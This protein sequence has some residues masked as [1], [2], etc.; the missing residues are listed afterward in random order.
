MT[1]SETRLIGGR[2]RLGERLGTGAMGIVWSAY[3]ELLHRN[4]AVKEVQLP[5]GMPDDEADAVRERTLREARAVAALNQANVITVFDVAVTDGAPFVV[6]ELVTGR[7]LAGLLRASG[8]LDEQAA[9]LIAD[10][11][12]AALGAAHRTG[13]THRDVKPGNVLLGDGG[14]VRLTDFG[15]A[16]SVAESTMTHTGIILGSPAYIAP[17]IAEG[18]KAAP[19]ADLWSLGATLF[20]AVTGRPPYEPDG[21]IVATLHQVVDGEVPDPE[22]D[23][24]LGEVVRGLMVKDPQA[25]L[26]LLEI[27]RLVHPLLPAPGESLF[28]LASPDPEPVPIP[29]PAPPPSPKPGAEAATAAPL[30]GDPGPLPFTP[31]APAPR[32]RRNRTT[33]LVVAAIVLFLL[34]GTG[35]FVAAR[36]IGGQSILPQPRVVAA[37]APTR[38]IG[39]L[40]RQEGR[41]QTL[42]GARGGGFS[43]MVPKG[44]PTFVEQRTDTRLPSAAVVHFVSED[45]QQEITVERYPRFFPAHTIADYI[46]SIREAWPAG[47]LST[48]RAKSGD[49]SEF[50]YRTVESSQT[51]GQQGAASTDLGRTVYAKAKRD[52][53]ILWVVSVHV[54]TEQEDKGYQQLY[55]RIAPTFRAED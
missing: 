15:I 32:P 22:V 41:A 6:M 50:M 20:A 26:S 45:G 39:E 40:V 19:A 27:R 4:V 44:W 23:G 25:R 18:A 42:N 11:L 33:G 29:A 21:G 36:T 35:T 10:A 38:P 2:Y 30:A 46:R 54:P 43:I 52:E 24:P 9:A 8:P 37:D 12:A 13:I 48:Q 34:A 17:E 5:A 16:R 49:S 31:S 55:Q 1:D 7:S 53:S 3:D 51:D 47:D 28:D 14:Q